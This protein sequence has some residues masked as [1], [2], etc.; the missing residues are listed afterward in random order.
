MAGTRFANTLL[1]NNKKQAE[2]RRQI[3]RG[4]AKKCHCLGLKLIARVQISGFCSLT[5]LLF[6]Y[7]LMTRF[8]SRRYPFESFVFAQGNPFSPQ[9]KDIVGVKSQTDA[10]HKLIWHPERFACSDN[11]KKKKGVMLI[12]GTQ[13]E[14]SYYLLILFI[15]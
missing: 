4:R 1:Q 14:T 7:C 6:A 2:N 11:F 8:L 13:R 10:L 15:Y 3:A 9:D 5:A 12:A